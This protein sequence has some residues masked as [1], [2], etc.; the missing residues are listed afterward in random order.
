MTLSIN[1]SVKKLII[2]WPTRHEVKA[3][4]LALAPAAD[5]FITISRGVRFKAIT[6]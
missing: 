5:T 2:T 3:R 1:W 6:E 4:T